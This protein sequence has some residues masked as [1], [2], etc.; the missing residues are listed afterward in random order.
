[1]GQRQVILNCF[2]DG[3]SLMVSNSDFKNTQ[4]SHVIFLKELPPD[5]H[6]SILKME[7]RQ[8]ELDNSHK[9]LFNQHDGEIMHEK[10]HELHKLLVP[11]YGEQRCAFCGDV[12]K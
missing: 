10:V 11:K 8:I 6:S 7:L 3:T 5:Q 12:F 4:E 9:L 1:M 2:L